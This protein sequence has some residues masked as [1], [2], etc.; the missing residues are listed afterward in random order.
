MKPESELYWPPPKAPSALTL[1]A[2]Y[3]SLTKSLSSLF[4][5]LYSTS[6]HV[7]MNMYEGVKE[8]A[9]MGYEA[10]ITDAALSSTELS[11][12]VL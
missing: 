10:F 3:V 1:V 4:N 7:S 5:L 11:L 2:I 8:E 6:I 9:K 12:L